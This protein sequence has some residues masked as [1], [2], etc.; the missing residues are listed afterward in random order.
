HRQERGREGQTPERKQNSDHCESWPAWK[1]CPTRGAHK[2]GLP[3]PAALYSRRTRVLEARS[4]AERALVRAGVE[5][6]GDLCDGEP[7]L[8]VGVV[9]VRTEA[10]AGVRP[11]V[12]EDLTFR[13]LLV[14]RLEV[15]R[16]HRDG[17]AASRLVPGTADLEPRLVAEIDRQLRLSNRVLADAVDAD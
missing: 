5:D 4:G 17:A 10:Q 6:L 12:A 9:V 2:D 3:P 15:R 8:V 7:E 13:E 1:S 11:E 14:H 16:S